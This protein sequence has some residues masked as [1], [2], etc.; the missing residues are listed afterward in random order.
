M[1]SHKTW[2]W[3][4]FSCTWSKTRRN[5]EIA[6]LTTSNRPSRESM[7]SLM[8]SFKKEWY[9]PKILY[10][11][12]DL[13]IFIFWKIPSQDFSN[14]KYVF[15][16]MKNTYYLTKWQRIFK[17]SLNF[18]ITWKNT[19][20]LHRLFDKRLCLTW[21]TFMVHRVWM[22]F[23]EHKILFHDKW[24]VVQKRLSLHSLRCKIYEAG[25]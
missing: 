11:L 23:N 2:T 12:N 7:F 14:I 18:W 10:L 22:E 21:M 24:F 1:Q 5:L 6:L 15:S 4:C 3:T 13:R 9:L 8:I 16:N 17:Y 25:E 19:L 20:L